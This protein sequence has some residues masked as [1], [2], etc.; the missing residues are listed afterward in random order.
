MMP[1][2]HA[3]PVRIRN[4]SEGGAKLG[5]KWNGWLPKGFDLEDTFTGARRAVQSVWRQFSWMG[6]RF[7]NRKSSDAR[8]PEFGHRRSTDE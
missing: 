4:E 3:M 8:H 7:R 2:G 6:V 1:S 5:V